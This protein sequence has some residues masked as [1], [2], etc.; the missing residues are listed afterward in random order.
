[1]AANE[2]NQEQFDAILSSSLRK[3]KIKVAD[4]FVDNVVSRLTQAQQQK[5]LARV[6]LQERL[7]LAGCILLPVL[8]VVGALIFPEALRVVVGF[9]EGLT[10]K[11]SRI[12]EVVSSASR[13][14]LGFSNA[15]KGVWGPLAITVAIGVAVYSV[16]DLLLTDSQ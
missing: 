16:V 11:I 5:I 2:P 1:M 12:I 14:W 6:I 13:L 3:K 7:A 8:A 10:G 9:T 15:T 4:G